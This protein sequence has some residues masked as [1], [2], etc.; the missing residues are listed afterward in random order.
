[1]KDEIR[2]HR[3]S[4]LILILG[5]SLIAIAFLGVWP[6]RWL[7]RAVIAV[8]VVFYTAWGTITHLH[9]DHITKRVI[10]EYASMSLLAGILLLLV[11]I[12]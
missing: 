4:Y 10:S 3:W 11:T 8:M 7:Q 2:K 6:D 5:M 1:M 9:A 12:S